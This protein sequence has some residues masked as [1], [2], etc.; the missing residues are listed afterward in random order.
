ISGSGGT[1]DGN[2]SHPGAGK[3][4]DTNKESDRLSNISINESL[5]L[6]NSSSNSVIQHQDEQLFMESLDK[7]VTDPLLIQ[8]QYVKNVVDIINNPLTINYFIYFLESCD[9]AGK[10]GRFCMEVNNFVTATKARLANYQQVLQE[11]Q[12]LNNLEVTRQSSDSS[13][14]L[15]SSNNVS[16]LERIKCS[17]DEFDNIN[18]SKD[19][20]N[21]NKSTDLS[22]RHCDNSKNYETNKSVGNKDKKGLVLPDLV[23]G[24]SESAATAVTPVSSPQ[25]DGTSQ[26]SRFAVA[27]CSDGLFMKDSI[28]QFISEQQSVENDIK[29]NRPHSNSC[30][31][32][33]NCSIGSSTKNEDSICDSTIESPNKTSTPCKSAKPTQCIA[34][35]AVHIFN[36]YLSHD[37]SCFIEI[38]DTER[39]TI[40][41]RICGK[42]KEVELNCFEEVV[43]KVVE[44]LEK[45]Y[46]EK[47]LSS[48]WYLRH[49]VDVLTSG[50]VHLKDILESD[51]AFALFME[52]CEQSGGRGLLE[53]WV[54]A[55]N[56]SEHLRQES[57]G[58][59]PI[60]AQTDA[61]VLYDK[62]FSLQARKPLGFSDK[63]RFYMESNICHE[64]G[65]KPT[66][67]D[68]PLQISLHVLD[69]DFLPGYLNS[70]LHSKYIAEIVNTVRNSPE[71]LGRKKRSNSESTVS[72]SEAGSSVF[73]SSISR[74]NTLLAAQNPAHQ[75]YRLAQSSKTEPGTVPTAETLNLRID[76]QQIM[77]PDSLWR[78]K[79]FT[80][81]SCGYI[82]ELGKFESEIQN[83]PDRKVEKSLSRTLKK[84]VNLEEDSEKESRA[85]AAAASIIE[86]VTSVT[87]ANQTTVRKGHYRSSSASEA[88]FSVSSSSPSRD[89]LSEV[90]PSS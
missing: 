52:Y 89:N 26:E 27:Q 25:T 71:I 90:F 48:D 37:A 11:Q 32:V 43:N 80:K 4:V 44:L 31:D 51:E 21:G 66:C 19:I 24:I 40:M 39:Q 83:P 86:E 58:Y 47:F 12:I 57:N 69:R 65:P 5:D 16:D 64:D 79:H 70:S 56:F 81:L 67:F 15:C 18:I 62:F 76:A 77:D 82:N 84:F 36:K 73:G 60:Q 35:E 42:Y 2:Q 78:R 55:S 68:V 72:S 74:H 75:A 53:F 28:P 63:V 61:M 13:E 17:V 3:S 6:L 22:D 88:V 45:E 14:L 59:D 10:Y 20:L 34:D 33:L 41:E 38:S 50:E 29:Q 1:V 46:F 49:Q 30:K 23:S 8:S 9:G 87:M 54:A 7:Q 85:W